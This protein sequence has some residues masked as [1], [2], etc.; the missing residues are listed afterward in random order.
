MPGDVVV[1]RD[2]R[3]RGEVRHLEAYVDAA[4]ALHVD[5]HDIGGDAGVI[6]GDAE[7]EWWQK[8][9]AKDVPRLLDLLK[10]EPGEGILDVLRRAYAGDGA[11][12]LER[13]LRESGIP[14]ELRSWS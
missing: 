5:G 13:V 11:A 2:E 4:G 6:S 1:L 14:V 12:E 8:V 7:Y 10:P 9:A 3:R